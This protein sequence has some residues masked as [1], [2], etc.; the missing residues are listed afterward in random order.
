[1]GAPIRVA[2]NTAEW[3]LTQDQA[4]KLLAALESNTE[5]VNKTL[6]SIQGSFSAEGVEFAYH[7]LAG[8]LILDIVAVHSF[9]AKVA[10]H[11]AI[12]DAVNDIITKSV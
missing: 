2:P 9:K 7:Y 1:M 5:I 4:T 10:G 3:P 12:F 8:N 6:G 11:D